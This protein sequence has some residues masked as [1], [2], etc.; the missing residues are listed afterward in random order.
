MSAGSGTKR[1]RL[2]IW[3]KSLLNAYS[4]CDSLISW[5]SI[6]KGKQS[7]VLPVLLLLSGGGAFKRQHERE[8]GG[9]SWE[10]DRAGGHTFDAWHGTG[11]GR[12]GRR[13]TSAASRST[14]IWIRH[15]LPIPGS[16]TT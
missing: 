4:D 12:R 15:P 2:W 8:E 14:I 3:H 6:D 11:I 7:G 9:A 10:A 16:L 5:S 13:A 1:S